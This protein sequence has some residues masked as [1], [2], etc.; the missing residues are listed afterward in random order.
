M[1]QHQLEAFRRQK[2]EVFGGHPQSP[3]PA[4][5]RATFTGL[6][7]YPHD[8]ALVFELTPEPGD[9]E[10]LAIPTSDGD[11]RRYTRAATIRFTV[12]GT[13]AEL[14]LLTSEQQAGFFLP[15]RDA[16]SGRETYG[17]GRY[18]DVHPPHD[19]LVHVDFNLAYNPYCAYDDAYSCP[20][21][22]P[23][24]WLS[25][26]IRAGERTYRRA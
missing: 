4:T 2:D 20:L 23:D 25:V 1:D 6:S 16:T 18:L 11:E 5:D 26:P 24:N 21:P 3:V 17:A 8:P 7:Y 19:G 14:V 22:P 12:D 10:I 13:S 9:G 15:F